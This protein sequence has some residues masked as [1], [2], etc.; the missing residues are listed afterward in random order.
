VDEFC[1][2]SPSSLWSE[3]VPALVEG[4]RAKET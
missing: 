2:T 1:H 3:Q 4:P